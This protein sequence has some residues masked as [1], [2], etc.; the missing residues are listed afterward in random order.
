MSCEEAGVM[1]CAEAGV[2]PCAEAGVMPCAE[3][4]VMPCAE[5]GVEIMYGRTNP[6][7]ALKCLDS[8]VL[9]CPFAVIE[10]HSARAVARTAVKKCGFIII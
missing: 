10:E 5:A 4:G 3:A 8:N 1:S 2:M 7:F 9:L 6:S